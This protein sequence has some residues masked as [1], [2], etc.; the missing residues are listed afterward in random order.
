MKRKNNNMRGTKGYETE[1]EA[2]DMTPVDKS[3]DIR[4]RLTEALTNHW[5]FESSTS[6]QIDSIVNV[7]RPKSFKENE[8][9]WNIFCSTHYARVLLFQCHRLA[10]LFLFTTCLV[11]TFP[12]TCHS[13]KF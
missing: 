6:K 5:L 7:M 11:H 9:V 1:Q 10:L 2:P 13:H 4:S 8:N 3:D 12:T